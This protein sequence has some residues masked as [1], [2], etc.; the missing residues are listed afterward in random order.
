MKGSADNFVL[1]KDNVP[2]LKDQLEKAICEVPN[3]E[4]IKNHIDMTVTN[5]GLRIN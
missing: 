3:F 4:K 2:D 5:E 1:S